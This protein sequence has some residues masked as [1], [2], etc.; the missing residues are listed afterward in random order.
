[1][2]TVIVKQMSRAPGPEGY[3]GSNFAHPREL[4]IPSHPV[5]LSGRFS[6][7]NHHDVTTDSSPFPALNDR[8]TAGFIP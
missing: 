2:E 4:A 3:S 5:L 6:F 1:M 8:P 7:G